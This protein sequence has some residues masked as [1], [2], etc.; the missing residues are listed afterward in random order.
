MRDTEA[1]AAASTTRTPIRTRS[2]V[3]GLLVGMLV[4]S[5]GALAIAPPR[6]ARFEARLPWS[7]ALPQERDW[8]RAA[9]TGESVR[10]EPVRGG[11]ELRVQAGSAAE[12]RLLTR[13]FAS[14]HAP[15]KEELAA[16]FERTRQAWR[17]AVTSPA[18]GTHN[19]SVECAAVLMARMRW[20]LELARDL[21]LAAP[22]RPTPEPRPTLQVEDAWLNVTW[23]VDE[24]DPALLMAAVV[25]AMQ[26][27]QRWFTNDAS[28]K[29]WLP[30]A[31]AEAWRRWQRS[32][33]KLLEPIA[34]QIIAWESRPQR[35]RASHAAARQLVALDQRV[36]DPWG[37]FAEQGVRPVRPL[38][39][40]I[41]SVWLPP[42]LVGAGVGSL[43]TL[44]VLLVA[45]LF[46]SVSPR[47]RALGSLG[48]ATDPGALTPTL[49]V[50][51]GARP[52]L[53][54]RAA[55][56][57]AAHRIAAGDRVLL[58]DG[59]PRLRLHDRIGRDARW[60]LLECLAADM[61]V[62]GLVQYAGHPGLYLLPHGKAERSVGWSQLGRKLD[63]VL[64]HFGR[65]ILAVDSQ[66][67]GAV[68]DALRGRAMEG[69]WAGGDDRFPRA[70]ESAMSRLGI[71]FSPL[72]LADL[73]EPSLEAM[74]SRVVKLRPPGEPADLAPITAPAT[75]ELRPAPRPTLEPIVLDCDLQVRQRLRF[76]AWMRRV[77]AE[78]RSA[79]AQATT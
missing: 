19:R 46:R 6:G 70:A 5:C 52:G 9:R 49:H 66:A 10:I 36:G 61:P 53:V 15:T 78:G 56:E 40:P 27:D 63:E 67:P 43:A 39:R 35:A 48:H 38:V 21:P 26:Y 42:L 17:A 74:A 34:D 73:S 59:S 76:L 45:T 32:R 22:S 37:A 8:P 3:T 54:L 69:W 47:V 33:A 13:A 24:R 18:P 7:A 44:L 60:G 68:G 55:L 31:R 12:A 30:T 23:V 2:I 79:G 65:I 71:A 14:R 75:V 20:G 11:Q 41:A 1:A 64:P 50:V 29:G 77:Q 4:G 25:E 28:W 72:S 51:T 62:L 58:V 16:R 57:L